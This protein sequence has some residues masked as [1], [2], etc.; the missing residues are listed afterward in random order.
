[1]TERLDKFLVSQGIG[2]RKEVTR[3]VRRGSVMVDGKPTS[4]ADC[5]IDP[6]N[7][8]V[9]VEGK[10]I[11]YRRFLYIMMNKPAGVLSATEDRKSRTVLDLLP[12][13]LSRRGLFP[14]GRLD[15]DT[16]GLL[17]LTDD[18]E[19]AHR[20]LSP[21]SHVYKRYAAAGRYHVCACTPVG[22]RIPGPEDGVCGDQRGK[23]SSGKT[24]VRSVRQPGGVSEETQ[25]RRSFSG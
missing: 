18:G 25:D 5:K 22:G 7:S 20:M 12:P 19:F 13:P 3:L 14:A 15:K 9:T 8:K 2:S 11:V 21:K 1:M 10:E 4:T 17:I 24:N 16:T 23:I 6:E